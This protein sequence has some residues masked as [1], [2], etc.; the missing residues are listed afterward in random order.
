MCTLWNSAFER[1]SPHH[2]FSGLRS[3]H[4]LFL[5]YTY[6]LTWPI[7]DLSAAFCFL[8]MN[9][10]ESIDAIVLSDLIAW[11]ISLDA[12]LSLDL[13]SPIPDELLSF[14]YGMLL[15]LSDLRIWWS[16]DG[17]FWM[18]G[19]LMSQGQVFYPNH[20]RSRF[21]NS[22]LCWLCWHDL[23]PESYGFVFQFSSWGFS[24][25]PHGFFVHRHYL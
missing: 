25:T 18:H 14:Y 1:I 16:H 11:A 10:R 13:L 4:T 3:S 20:E 8:N 5:A 21:F 9:F 6:V 24:E 19:S 2:C 17:L 15:N 7:H 23:I 12:L 22:S